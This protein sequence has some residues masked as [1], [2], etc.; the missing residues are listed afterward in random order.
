MYAYLFRTIQYSKAEDDC[1]DF[2]SGNV[3]TLSL[4]PIFLDSNELDAQLF[5]DVDALLGNVF[6]GGTHCVFCKLFIGDVYDMTVSHNSRT[7]FTYNHSFPRATR[8][9]IIV[10]SRDS[11]L[12]IADCE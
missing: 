8:C 3:V 2:S 1:R 12:Q 7:L 5:V 4:S 10:L 11:S 9:F 6:L